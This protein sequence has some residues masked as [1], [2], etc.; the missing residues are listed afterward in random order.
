MRRRLDRPAERDPAGRTAG[1]RCASAPST[2]PTISSTATAPTRPSLLTGDLAKGSATSDPDGYPLYYAGSRDNKLRS[3]P[4]IGGVRRLLW[5]LDSYTGRSVVWNDDWDGAPLVVRGH[6]LVGGENS[7]FYVIGSIAA[8][9]RDGKVRVGRAWSLACP[10][11]TAGCLPH[12]RTVRSRSSDRSRITAASRTSPTPPG[13]CRAGTSSDAARPGPARAACSGSGRRR[14]RRHD[15]RRRARA[16]STCRASW[17]ASR[18]APAQV[19]QLLKLDPRRPRD[20][21][22]WSVPYAASVAARR[23]ARGRRRPSTGHVFV[24]TNAGGVVAVDRR[25]GTVRWTLDLAGPT[26]GRRWSSTASC[27]RA[28]A[29]GRCTRS[30]SQRAAPAA[31]LWRSGSAAASSRPGRLA[32][33]HL[34]RHARRRDVRHPRAS[35]LVESPTR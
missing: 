34:R 1:W 2:A 16:T 26:W 5:A 29:S 11:G 30:T 6:L 28:T 35:A 32:R 3:S 15:R 4:S 10:A 12:V 23:R 24:A 14:H 22:V 8:T 31:A 25:T 27:S 33:A 21:V 18:T 17:S 19:G 13:S 9:D 20:P 7:W